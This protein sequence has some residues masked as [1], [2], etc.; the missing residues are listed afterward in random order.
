MYARPSV[1]EVFGL[2]P[3]AERARDALRTFRG[4]PFTP[5]SRF[6]RTSL[7]ILKPTLSIPLWL[8]IPARG[9]RVPIYNLFNHTR[10]PIEDGWSVR[11][12]QVRDFR[13][14]ALTY[15]SHNGTDFAI[16]PGTV[17]VAAAPGR[18]VRVSN[19]FD[20]GGLK[21][22]VDHGDGL[23]T[24][25]NH[26][27]RALVRPGDRVRR[28]EP[29]ALS[30]MSGIDGL[31]LFPWSTPHVHFN[32]WLDGAYVDPFALP[33]EVSLWRSANDP[34]PHRPAPGDDDETIPDTAW[35]H[36]AVARAIAGCR[37]PELR[38]QLAAIDDPIERAA[39]VLFQTNYYPTRFVERPSLYLTKSERRPRLDLPFS[40]RDFD[41]IVFPEG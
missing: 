10:P 12:T 25:S 5:P 24:T 15:D 11:V 41:G 20:R 31:L 33:G 26:L 28:G 19:E 30:G 3:F 40:W 27:S 7:R 17:V 34:A 13:G 37:D 22:F 35:D 18:V 23:I 38:V 4:D 21:V 9:R 29:I 2:S 1:T 32:V 14:G 8:G 36:D 6:D 16:P 39:T